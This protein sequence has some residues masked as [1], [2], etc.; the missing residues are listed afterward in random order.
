MNLFKRGIEMLRQPDRNPRCY[1]LT[2]EEREAKIREWQARNVWNTP[3]LAEQDHPD[4]QH[5]YGA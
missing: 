2:K 3:E 5:Y 4:N 1:E